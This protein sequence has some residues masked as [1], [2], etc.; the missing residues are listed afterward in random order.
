[1]PHEHAGVAAG[2]G[3]DADDRLLVQVLR[4]VR[5]QP[6]LPDR[7]HDVLRREEEPVEVRALHRAAAPVGRDAAGR[8]PRAPRAS[9]RHAPR[10][11]RGRGPAATGRTPPARG[12]RAGRRAPRSSVRRSTTT[13]RGARLISGVLAEPGQQAGDHRSG[14]RTRLSIL[15]RFA[16]SSRAARPSSS[17]AGTSLVRRQPGRLRLAARESLEPARASAL[18]CASRSVR[19]AW[20]RPRWRPRRRGGLLGLAPG[21]GAA[22]GDQLLLP[23]GELDL[24]CQLVLA[25]RPLPLDRERPA[26]VHGPVGVLLHLLTGRRLQGAAPSRAP[27]GRDH[28][29]ADHAMPGLGEPRDRLARPAVDRVADRGAMPPASSAARSM[30]ASRSSA[31]CCAPL[32]EQAGDLVQRLPRQRPVHRV[33]REVQPPRPRRPGR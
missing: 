7:D 3:V 32:G 27:G 8:P 22:L 12:C 16:A 4:H 9:P 24:V 21:V 31:C 5:H 2:L 26:L 6:V 10:P 30:V 15:G 28:P 33:D 17:S 14:V 1:M 18:A 13:T 20:P 19:W 29:D 25:D 11:P 23:P